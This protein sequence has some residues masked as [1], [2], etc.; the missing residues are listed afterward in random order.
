MDYGPT[1]H[2]VSCAASSALEQQGSAG[3]VFGVEVIL[4][5]AQLCCARRSPCEEHNEANAKHWCCAA[6]HHP[7]KDS[8]FAVSIGFTRASTC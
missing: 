4:G 2:G 7:Q 3:H 5:D 6:S 8:C 1:A